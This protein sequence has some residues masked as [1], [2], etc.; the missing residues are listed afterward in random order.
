MKKP[1]N[2][3]IEDLQNQTIKIKKNQKNQNKKEFNVTNTTFTW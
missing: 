3:K 2:E 1:K